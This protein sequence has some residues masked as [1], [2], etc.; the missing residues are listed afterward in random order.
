MVN[1]PHKSSALPAGIKLA[2]DFAPLAVFFI[3]FKFAGVMAATLALIVATLVSISIIYFY[4]RKIALAPLISGIL[5]TVLGGLSVILHN[6]QFIKMK[7][8]LVNL[9]FAIT[10]IGGVVF[11]KRGLLKHILDMAFHLTEEGWKI[12]SLRW[13][14]FFLFLAGLN[15]FIWRNFSTDF[16]VN[17]KVF[18][19]FTLTA[20]FAVS[21]FKLVEKY[22][23]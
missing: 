2:L 18:G 8:T 10:L 4:E 17:F 13:G 21:Q 9:L 22:K 1:T 11:F 5:V 20:V 12:L 23:A 7:P 14:F 19:M 3:A 6:E 16:W 15:E